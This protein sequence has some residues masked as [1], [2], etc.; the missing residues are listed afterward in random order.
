MRGNWLGWNDNLMQDGTLLIGL[1]REARPI[2]REPAA[3]GEG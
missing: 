2:R 3:Y 1:D